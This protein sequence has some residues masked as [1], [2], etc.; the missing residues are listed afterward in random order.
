MKKDVRNM[1]EDEFWEYINRPKP[2]PINEERKPLHFNTKEEWLNYYSDGMN[3]E[4]FLEG[5]KDKY[6]L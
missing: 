2:H 1:S 5:I 3:F 6:G 4:D